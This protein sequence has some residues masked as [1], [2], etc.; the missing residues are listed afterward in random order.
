MN[1][2]SLITCMLLVNIG[3][4][5]T[6][7]QERYKVYVNY[8]DYTAKAEVIS[9]QKKIKTV[10]SLI[11]SW[12]GSNKIIKTQGGYTG[13]L[14]DGNYNSFYLSNNLKE[15]GTYKKGLYN[16]KWIIW[17]E[18]GNLKEITYWRK[19]LKHGVSK[20]FNTEGVVE[21]VAFFKKGRE[22]LKRETKEKQAK[23]EDH[24]Y[25]KKKR[26]TEVSKKN[27]D[28]NKDKFVV[29]TN[30][31]TQ[32]EKPKPQAIILEPDSKKENDFLKDNIKR[33]K[34]SI[35]KSLQEND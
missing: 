9:E 7:K 18:N 6:T 8:I 14:L 28:R 13:K 27:T 25:N 4:A 11:Y 21:K 31:K 34:K 24:A 35:F 32:V 15:R 20:L 26:K 19:G 3:L 22:K 1:K 12:Y 29:K 30:K 2:L 17:Y 23:N 16:G 33:E 10:D 5:Q